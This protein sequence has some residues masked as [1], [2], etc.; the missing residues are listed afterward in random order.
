MSHDRVI[1]VGDVHGCR[2]EFLELLDHVVSISPRDLLVLLGDLLGKG[3]SG[4][5][6][7]REVRKRA[8]SGQPMVYLLGNH[9]EKFLRYVA[10]LG[11]GGKLPEDVGG[12]LAETARCLA[13]EDLEFLRT[14]PR[15]WVAIPGRNAVAIHAG[16]TPHLPSLPQPD[17]ASLSRSEWHQAGQLLRVRHVR[18]MDQFVLTVCQTDSGGRALGRRSVAFDGTPIRLEGH[19][20]ITNARVR[21][22]GGMLALGTESAADP[23]WADVYDGRF[24][25]IF[26]GHSAHLGSGRPRTHPHATGLDLGCVYGGHLAA[27]VLGTDDEISFASVR[28][29]GEYAKDYAE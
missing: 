29:K 20:A 24:G 25:H 12:G 23:F 13:P 26:Y 4:P 14:F 7:L 27:A 10:T 9:E 15:L 21:R 8:E 17:P 16:V 11:S 18:G 19:H 22:A 6:C 2:E 1:I 5:E 28:A 3:P